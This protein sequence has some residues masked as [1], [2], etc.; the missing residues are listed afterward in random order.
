MIEVDYVEPP[1]V[2]DV[3]EAMAPDAPLL[4]DDLYTDGAEPWPEQ[5]SDIAK[6][7][8]LANVACR[9]PFGRDRSG[10]NR[11]PMVHT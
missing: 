10:M 2:I 8:R 11:A 4:Q 7:Y 9:K 6:R 5:P 3:V 1:H